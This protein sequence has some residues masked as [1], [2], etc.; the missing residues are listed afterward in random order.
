MSKILYFIQSGGFMSFSVVFVKI[1]KC[2]C[3]FGIYTQTDKRVRLKLRPF[4]QSL[5]TMSCIKAEHNLYINRF[6]ECID[7]IQMALKKTMLE[8]EAVDWFIL[9]CTFL[10]P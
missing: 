4:H 9:I 8:L 6:S 1:S 5:N 7:H 2:S 3:L 10:H